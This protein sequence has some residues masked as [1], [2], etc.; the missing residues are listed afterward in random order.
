MQEIIK[1]LLKKNSPEMKWVRLMH[2]LGDLRLAELPKANYD[3]SITQIEIL[4]FVGLN[5]GCHI[6]DVSDNLGLTPP[7]IS[8]S[9]RRL[10]EDH[11][12]EKHDDP[13]DRRAACIFLTEKSKKALKTALQYQIAIVKTFL[14]ELD[15]E[16][17]EQLLAL[18][19]KAVTGMENHQ[20]ENS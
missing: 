14:K 9:I 20:K 6:Q 8:V 18:L 10:E 2:R 17:Q 12:L 3:L 15:S 1:E 5:P 7:T 13:N 19:E 4:R 16:E 11:W